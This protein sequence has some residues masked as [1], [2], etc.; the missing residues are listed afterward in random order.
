VQV[1]EVAKQVK[2]LFDRERARLGIGLGRLGIDRALPVDAYR[3]HLPDRRVEGARLA[4]GGIF[5]VIDAL[6]FEH[7]R[8]HQEQHRQ[9]QHAAE[10]RP[11]HHL[12]SFSKQLQVYA[13]DCRR[14]RCYR[15][16]PGTALTGT[17]FAPTSRCVSRPVIATGTRRG[18]CRCRANLLKHAWIGSNNC[19]SE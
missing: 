5:R 16:R 7:A 13:M 12:D 8:R 14:C 15:R 10:D 9:R 17:S 11:S 1:L 6:P 2:L 19:L 4:A 18:R 3:R